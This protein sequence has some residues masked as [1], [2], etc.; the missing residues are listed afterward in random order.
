VRRGAGE[1]GKD[2]KVKNKK[3]KKTDLIVDVV[4]RQDAGEV[5]SSVTDAQAKQRELGAGVGAEG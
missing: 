1:G 4:R 2:G 5:A 3:K